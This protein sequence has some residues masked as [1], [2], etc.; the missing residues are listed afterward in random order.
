M[1]THFDTVAKLD[2]L[3]GGDGNTGV[4]VDHAAE[5]HRRFGTH[6]ELDRRYDRTEDGK[7][8]EDKGPLVD[9]SRSPRHSWVGTDFSISQVD[10]SSGRVYHHVAC[11]GQA[12]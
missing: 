3:E 8:A 6:V 12:S 4:E 9:D 10:P 1:G 2:P 7:L 5:G 11:F